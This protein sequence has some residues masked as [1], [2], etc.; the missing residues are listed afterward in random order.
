MSAASVISQLRSLVEKA[1]HLMP[2][3]NK[4]YPTEEQW[5]GLYDLSKKLTTNATILNNKTQVLKKTRAD[6][7]WKES[8]KLRSQALACQGDLL[9]NGRLKQLTVFRRNIITIFEGPKDSKFDSE[10][11]RARKAMTRQRCEKIRQLSH[12]G[13]VS[14]AI[15]F[16]P[17]LWAGG[18]MATDIF[19]CLLDDI[20]PDQ[21]PSWPSVIR[22]TLYMLREDESS[23]Q[24]SPEYEDFLKAHDKLPEEIKGRKK[25]RRCDDQV[26]P[27][28]ADPLSPSNERRE[29][30]H[31]YTNGDPDCVDA[32]PE[33]FKRI[34]WSSR[35]WNWERSKGM[36][37]TGCLATL[38]PK[39]NTQDVSLTIWCGNYEAYHLNS[40][41]G[42]QLAAS[43]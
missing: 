25:R 31:M 21:P 39:D 13:I 30:K 32:L 2:K 15:T 19:T 34:I 9:T 11:M 14:W 40:I 20:E 26:Q 37:T 4:I 29:M 16:P 8:E 7:A 18:S 23:L 36:K 41:L 1:E 33:P 43:S 17:S 3:L 38:F 6:R 42:L 10:D 5:C 12:D 35:L 28:P 22:E 27:V 24:V